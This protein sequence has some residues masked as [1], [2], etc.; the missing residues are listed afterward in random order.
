LAAYVAAQAPHDGAPVELWA[1]EGERQITAVLD[2]PSGGVPDWAGH[3]AAL[4]MELSAEWL[5]WTASAGQLRPQED[6]A[7]F[8]EDHLRDFLEPDAATMLELV[9]S[10]QGR[11]N[12]A[13][14][15][16][17]LVASGQR[18]FGWREQVEAQAGAK[19]QLTVPTK[20]KIA[21]PVFE[22]AAPSTVTALFKYRIRSG[23]LS[24]G[25]KLL[26]VD[27]AERAA[28]GAVVSATAEVMPGRTVY[29]GRP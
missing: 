29:W 1:D 4:V 2:P 26:D 23:G 21:V 14:E 16:T 3:R 24:L 25:F 27:E 5:D 15:S 18:S 20:V 28:F 13:W 10:L 8:V 19:G 9:Q 11:T 6:A 22:G 17:H 7:V 12:V